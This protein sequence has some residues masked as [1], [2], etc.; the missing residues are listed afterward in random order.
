V[1]GMRG[2]RGWDFLDANAARLAACRLDEPLDGLRPGSSRLLRPFPA[3]KRPALAASALLAT[4]L[5][6]NTLQP[7]MVQA[8]GLPSISTVVLAASSPAYP[9]AQGPYQANLDD[10]VNR[11]GRLEESDK[12]QKREAAEAEKRSDDKMAAMEKRSDD[13]MAAMEKIRKQEAAEAAKE[14]KQEAAEAEKRSDDK[15]AAM[16]KRSDDKMAAMEVERKK[17]EERNFIVSAISAAASAASAFS[18]AKAN[19]IAKK[20]ARDPQPKP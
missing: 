14:R 13:K 2:K 1:T 6:L 20:I 9:A 7:S 10:L 18:A 3:S 17:G 15:M 5:S 12:S 4:C 19:E 11:L 8:A 16:E